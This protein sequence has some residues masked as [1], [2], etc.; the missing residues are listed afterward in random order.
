MQQCGC[1]SALLPRLD[2]QRHVVSSSED[3][4]LTKRQRANIALTGVVGED[5]SRVHSTDNDDDLNAALKLSMGMA[6][7]GLE[8]EG[9]KPDV[10]D[11]HAEEEKHSIESAVGNVARETFNMTTGNTRADGRTS[12]GD[13][14][15]DFLDENIVQIILASNRDENIG[16]ISSRQQDAENA[17][18]EMFRCRNKKKVLAAIDTLL[19]IVMNMIENPDEDKFK[20]VCSFSCLFPT[21]HV[22]FS[23]YNLE[24]RFASATKSFIVQSALCLALSNF[25]SPLASRTQEMKC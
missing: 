10:N 19:M 20:K 6:T 13:D 11:V 16:E 7:T 14:N 8:A 25:F 21:C 22:D 24:Q 23:S 2:N 4:V 9:C 17:V 15:E 12:D 1:A 18:V 5:T 3:T